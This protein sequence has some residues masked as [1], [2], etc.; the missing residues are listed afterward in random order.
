MGDVYKGEHVTNIKM[1]LE[2]TG[3]AV[4]NGI[5][6]VD[7]N[8]SKVTVIFKNPREDIDYSI[9]VTPTWNTRFWV[10]VIY[11]SGFVI[12]FSTSPTAPK[13]CYWSVIEV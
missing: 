3:N 13:N 10:T 2:T 8:E 4:V 1:P 9:I 12:N 6:Y 5:Q 7:T 11:S